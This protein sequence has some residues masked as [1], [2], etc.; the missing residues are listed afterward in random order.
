MCEFC[1]TLAET[2]A[3]YGN[4]I[5]TERKMYRFCELYVL[6]AYV[7][8]FSNVRLRLPALHVIP[9]PVRRNDKHHPIAHNLFHIGNAVPIIRIFNPCINS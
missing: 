1:I 4:P 3:F 2:R 7:T 5:C 9:A 8:V 6:S